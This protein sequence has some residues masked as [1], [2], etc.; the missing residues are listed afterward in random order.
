[1]IAAA[2]CWPKVG[3]VEM[4]K[5]FQGSDLCDRRKEKPETALHR[6]WECSHNK[7]S[8]VFDVSED[9]VIQATTQLNTAEA[10][11]LRGLIPEPWTRVP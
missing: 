11:W 2:G 6:Y 3:Q 1:M 5:H 7:G 4:I 9:L 8:K 10:F